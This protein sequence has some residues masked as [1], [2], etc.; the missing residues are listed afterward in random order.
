MYFLQGFNGLDLLKLVGFII[1]LYWI[2][3][4]L[5]G[6]GQVQK[7]RFKPGDVVRAI[8]AVRDD[9]AGTVDSHELFTI[10]CTKGDQVQ[11][12]EISDHWF[13]ASAFVRDTKKCV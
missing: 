4:F 13:R 6:V 12:V 7:S 8:I 2:A 9:I 5:Q 1:C 10:F 11:L 3:R